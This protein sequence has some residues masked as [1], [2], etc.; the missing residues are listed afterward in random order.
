MKFNLYLK[1]CREKHHLTQEELL[2]MLYN[3]DT[4]FENLDVGNISRW[5]RG[6][7]KP[8]M[9]RLVDII[10]V[11]GT[12]SKYTLPC[13]IDM[14]KSQ[15]ENDICKIGIK[16]LIGNSKEHI[17]NFPTKSFEV[18]DICIKH[19]RNTNDI[20]KILKMPYAVIENLTDNVYDLSFEKLK[21]WALHPSNLF[22][23]SEYKDE[24]SGILFTLRLKPQIFQKII[25]FD[26]DLTNI[27]IEDFASFDEMGS[28]LPISFFAHNNK[29][30]TLL[31]LRYYAHLIANQS[32]I[33]EV[34]S[35]PLLASAK[36]IVQKMHMKHY[37]DKKVSQGV[38]SS[39]YAPLS[40]VLINEDV[41]KMLFQKEKCP[42]D[43]I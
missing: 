25:Q 35:I 1:S 39:F 13:F 29:S 16:N 15:I 4:S 6:I 18:N 8:S 37:K 7:T 5:E 27:K 36:K 38:L 17:L 43:K 31:V 24:F 22:L 40:D 34:G 20:E 33:K 28:N 19:I 23:L 14:D 10:K 12:K 42:Q 41:M 30:S 9:N 2:Q 11:F 21:E 3:S 26:L 32:V